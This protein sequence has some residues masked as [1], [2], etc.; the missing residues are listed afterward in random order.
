MFFI[1]VC[2]KVSVL[3]FFVPQKKKNVIS[4]VLTALATITIVYRRC[5]RNHILKWDG[6]EHCNSQGYGNDIWI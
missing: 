3:L 1:F 2:K 4:L 5:K 6:L